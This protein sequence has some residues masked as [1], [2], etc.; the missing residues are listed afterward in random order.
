MR[1]HRWLLAFAAGVA[2]L[3]LHARAFQAQSLDPVDVEGQPLASNVTRLLQTLEFVGHPLP[4]DKTKALQAACQAQD[5]VKI[6]KLLDQH[7][8]F[9]VHINPE[10]RVKVK[11]GPADAVL[12]QGGYAPAIIKVTNDSTVTKKLRL[13]SPQALPNYDRGEAGKIKTADIKDRFLDIEMYDKAPLADKLSGLK[14][15]YAMALIHSSQA[16][17]REAM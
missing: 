1:H 8:L 17:K 7:A 13:T 15:E 5:A 14:A 3:L 12:Q 4:E 6:Q 16:G 9:L 10:A 11:R 2:A